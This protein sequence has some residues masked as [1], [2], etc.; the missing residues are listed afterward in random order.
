[1]GLVKEARR[2]LRKSAAGAWRW[3]KSPK[4]PATRAR[5]WKALWKVAKKKAAK[6]EPKLRKLWDQRRRIYRKRY[7]K[8]EKRAGREEK[9]D[10]PEIVVSPGSPH[11][12]GADD[13]LEREVEPVAV[14]HGLS[15]NSA[16]RSPCYGN[17]GS[18]HHESQVN[19]SARDFPTASNY[20]LRDEIM[21]ALGVQGPITDYGFYYITRAGRRYR[22]QPIAGTHGTGPHLHIGIRL[23]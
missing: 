6:V 18:D 22:V 13:I 15:P 7:K 23:A 21:R 14:R 19:A 3:A 8:Q 11:W 17:C 16:K 4:N 9:P 10:T 20:G 5:R 2:R 1:M 12:G